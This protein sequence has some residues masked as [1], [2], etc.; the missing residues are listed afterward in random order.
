ME[1]NFAYAERPISPPPRANNQSP[2]LAF[3]IKS[4]NYFEIE[5]KCEKKHLYC[6]VKGNNGVMGLS[7]R[8]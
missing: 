3:S 4:F 5:K 6:I 7:A 8:S 2:E 1:L